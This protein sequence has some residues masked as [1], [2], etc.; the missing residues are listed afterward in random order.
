[1]NDI[2]QR[3]LIAETCGWYKDKNFHINGLWNH[4]KYKVSRR[5]FEL[6]DYPNDLNAMFEA[7]ENLA[8]L[9]E[10]GYEHYLRWKLSHDF[11]HYNTHDLW[12]IWHST[13]RQRAEAFLKAIGAWHE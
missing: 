5:E 7:E 2:E 13:A 8:G 3:I 11:G 1:M 12:P 10:F 6:P 4:D 9:V